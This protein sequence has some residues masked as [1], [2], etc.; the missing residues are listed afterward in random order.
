MSLV[1]LNPPNKLLGSF[2]KTCKDFSRVNSAV[3]TA[4]PFNGSMRMKTRSW[5]STCTQILGDKHPTGTRTKAVF[6]IHFSWVMF[7]T[8]KNEVMMFFSKP[9]HLRL[10]TLE[11]WLDVN[12]HT[13]LTT[14]DGWSPWLAQAQPFGFEVVFSL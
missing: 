5:L 11:E 2:P 7:G 12:G 14:I 6:K 13:P 9:T 3:I 4:E 10:V 1:W 8:C